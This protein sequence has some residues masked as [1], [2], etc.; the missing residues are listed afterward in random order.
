MARRR[1]RFRR[2]SSSPLPTGSFD[3]GCRVWKRSA[4]T[5]VHVLSVAHGHARSS[6]KRSVPIEDGGDSFLSRKIFFAKLWQRFVKV[7]CDFLLERSQTFDVQTNRID[8][9]SGI[10]SFF[11]LSLFFPPSSSSFFV[12]NHLARRSRISRITRKRIIPH[13]SAA[14]EIGETIF[15]FELEQSDSLFPYLSV[16]LYIYVYIGVALIQR[17]I[18]LF[19]TNG[20]DHLSWNALIARFPSPANSVTTF[21]STVP[22]YT[23]TALLKLA[24]VEGMKNISRNIHRRD[25]SVNVIELLFNVSRFPDGSLVHF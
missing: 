22:I 21:P 25:T 12:Y 16:S 10:S 24:L 8:C 6:L 17:I 18:G 23:L 19:L 13:K 4:R 3:H 2:R 14:N 1:G 15:L 20:Y 7:A 5:S 11:P 9:C